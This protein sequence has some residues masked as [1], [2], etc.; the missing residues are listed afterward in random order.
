M[1][2]FKKAKGAAVIV[3]KHVYFNQHIFITGIKDESNV[4]YNQM[5][6]IKNKTS[7]SIEEENDEKFKQNSCLVFPGNR[8]KQ[9]WDALVVFL[10]LYTAIF[11]PFK[12]CFED[13]STD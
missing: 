3:R 11:V 13:E 7:K 2:A 8:L 10:L 9:V 1:L 12:V 4:K 6:H 5:D